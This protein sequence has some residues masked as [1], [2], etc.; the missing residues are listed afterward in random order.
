M[1]L[2]VMQIG[3]IK[4]YSDVGRSRL[5]KSLI[6]ILDKILEVFWTILWF[7]NKNPTT[8][9]GS[10]FFLVYCEIILRS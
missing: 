5:D 6:K 8:Y 9:V 4:I 7:L 10:N 2:F 1:S 3:K